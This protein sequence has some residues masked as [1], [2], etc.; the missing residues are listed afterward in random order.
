MPG[1][2]VDTP[3]CGFEELEVVEPVVDT[4]QQTLRDAIARQLLL[5]EEG[6]PLVPRQREEVIAVDRIEELVG[7]G[8]LVQREE[9][10]S[11]RD[12]DQLGRQVLKIQQQVPDYLRTALAATH[13]GD[14]PIGHVDRMAQVVIRVEDRVTE[15][16]ARPGR[17]IRH[18]PGSEHDVR[19][20]DHPAV[21]SYRKSLLVDRNLTHFGA[22]FNIGQAAGGP[23]QILVEFEATDVARPVD[24]TVEPLAGTKECQKGVR[25]GRIDQRDQV[26]EEG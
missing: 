21:E 25:A 18:K 15:M 5:I 3:T 9:V 20:A 6:I 14:G 26:L 12:P 23:L 13:H 16:W 1:E 7:E 17:N 8:R 2:Q 10:R 4:L 19:C 24:K 11:M 22:E